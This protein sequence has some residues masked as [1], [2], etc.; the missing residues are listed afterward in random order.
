VLWAETNFIGLGFGLDLLDILFPF[1]SS[2]KNVV[3]DLCSV[4]HRSTDSVGLGIH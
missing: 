4:C 2:F 1:L 3:W